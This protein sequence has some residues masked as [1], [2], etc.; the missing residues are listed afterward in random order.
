MCAHGSMSLVDEVILA[1]DYHTGRS[2]YWDGDILLA[3]V[4]MTVGIG[5]D[6]SL[7]SKGHR[8]C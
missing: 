1:V 6:L 7:A 3:T 5:G 8:F 4:V 2:L